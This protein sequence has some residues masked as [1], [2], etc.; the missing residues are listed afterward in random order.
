MG[1]RPLFASQM[2][3]ILSIPQTLFLAKSP[4]WFFPS[5]NT[6]EI[7]EVKALGSAHH[8][9][10]TFSLENKGTESGNPTK[11]NLYLSKLL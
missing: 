7:V 8:F 11:T 9:K 3:G 1:Q 2:L 6:E 5:Q 10:K 4:V